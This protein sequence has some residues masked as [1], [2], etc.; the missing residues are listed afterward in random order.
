MWIIVTIIVIGI[1]LVCYAQVQSSL[2]DELS[3]LKMGQSAQ[4][5]SSDAPASD[6][7]AP[8]T[9]PATVPATDNSWR[10][11]PS[12]DG[13]EASRE[14]STHIKGAD[15]TTYDAPVLYVTCYQN[16]YYIRLDTRLRAHGKDTVTIAVDGS[17]GQWRRSTGQNIFAPD[18]AGLLAYLAK[19]P[20]ASFTI[21]FDEAPAQKLTVRLN[22]LDSAIH[23]L[24]RWCPLPR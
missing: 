5:V 12:S 21:P 19:R 18:G 13:A 22:G 24:S 8:P 2:P 17:A 4:V 9:L 23:Q 3:F 7:G 15:G 11:L 20:E 1:G 14:L 10:I 16:N 6:A